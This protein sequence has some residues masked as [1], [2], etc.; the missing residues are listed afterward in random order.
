MGGFNK[1]DKRGGR[2]FDRGNFGGGRKFGGHSDIPKQFFPAICSQCGQNCEVPF[3]PTGERPVFCKNCF[4]S[5]DGGAPKFAPK[6]FGGNSRPSIGSSFGSQ[7]VASNNAGGA[8]TK[9]QLDSINAKLDKILG[10]LSPAPKAAEVSFMAE[11]QVKAKKEVTK[12]AKAPAKKV[13][14]KKK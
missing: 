11:P 8:V 12:K 14:T 13:G 9:A 2:G 7:A 4:R 5:Q 6:S 3:K 1:F 10:M